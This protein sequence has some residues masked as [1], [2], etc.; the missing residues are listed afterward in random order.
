M[1]KS[2]RAPRA[3]RLRKSE[4]SLRV[5]PPTTRASIASFG[6]LTLDEYVG[7]D[8]HKDN[9]RVFIE[10]A[11]RAASR[12]I[13]SFSAARPGSAR[14]RWRTSSRGRWASCSHHVGARPSSTR[15][16]SPGLLTKLEP[17]DVLFI[18]E[19]HRLSPTVEE[20]LYPAMEDFKIDIITGDGPYA[21]TYELPILPFTL[22]GA[23][24]RTGLLTAPLLSRF[25]YVDAARLLPA[26][27]ISRKIVRAQRAH[28]RDPDRRRRRA[29]L[30]QRSRGTPRV[31]NRLLR[32]ARD[33]AEVEGSGK[34]RPR[35]SRASR[36][37]GSRSTPPGSTR[38]TAACSG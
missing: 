11:R 7:Q 9:L 12:S 15:A 13:T 19:I 2:A 33:F 21:A 25:G 38:W 1:K 5:R 22:V 4:S 35:A 3:P 30:A 20:S 31:A 26:V 17:N 6:P 14:R 8:Q 23:T 24:T 29:E 34:H 37:S 28:A 16:R 10:A 32:R 36:A 18:D 27:A